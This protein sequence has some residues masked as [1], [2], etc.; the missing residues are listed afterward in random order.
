[1]AEPARTPDDPHPDDRRPADQGHDDQR[2]DARKRVLRTGKVVYG[3]YRY[4]V[5][6]TIRDFSPQ[7]VRLQSPT[8]QDVPDE[9][10]L[11]VKAD[12]RL[13]PSR[14]M[15]RK[16]KDIGV[17]FTGAPIDLATATDPRL[18]RFAYM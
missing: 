8:P 4:V 13:Y 11:F 2:H 7:G 10:F 6:C 15:W 1:M 5:D 14:A 17:M 9:F 3:D 12:G 16:G 18:N